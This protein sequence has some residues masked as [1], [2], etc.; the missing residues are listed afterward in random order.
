MAPVAATSFF[1]TGCNNASGQN[2]HTRGRERGWWEAYEEFAELIVGDISQLGAVVLGDDK[3]R[4][5]C[6]CIFTG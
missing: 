1:T 6:K 2:E 3:L 5:Q 4:R